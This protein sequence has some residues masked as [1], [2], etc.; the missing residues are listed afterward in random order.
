MSYMSK[1]LWWP[2]GWYIHWT[3]VRS[4]VTS[5]FTNVLVLKRNEKKV[6]GRPKICLKE[7]VRV[8]WVTV[9]WIIFYPSAHWVACIT[10]YPSTHWV[11]CLSYYP[12]THWVACFSFYPS[13]YWVH[14]SVSIL[15]PIGL[16]DITL[17]SRHNV[18]YKH[19]DPLRYKRRY[20]RS[21]T[22]PKSSYNMK[23]CIFLSDVQCTYVTKQRTFW[24][25]WRYGS[26]L[27]IQANK[28]VESSR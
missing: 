13:A 3:K 6:L 4:F 15:Q 22:L 11:A 10:F 12:S 23:C 8:E 28:L 26:T 25:S 7:I 5:W 21:P 17:P 19:I 24:N 20:E 18:I 9:W 1:H 2:T 16:Q 27:N 14:A